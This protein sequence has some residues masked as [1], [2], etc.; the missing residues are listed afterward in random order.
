MNTAV[1]IVLIAALSMGQAQSALETVR[2]LYADAAF[3]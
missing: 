3:E 2:D 1:A